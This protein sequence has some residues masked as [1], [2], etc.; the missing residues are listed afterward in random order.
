[1]RLTIAVHLSLPVLCSLGPTSGT[2]IIKAGDTVATEGDLPGP[3][4]A[5]ADNLPE[6]NETFTITLTEVDGAGAEIADETGV[7]DIID[8]TETRNPLS[9]PA[10]SLDRLRIR[11]GADK[12]I[13][14]SPDD[15]TGFLDAIAQG[16]S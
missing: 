14:V 4:Q 9:S 7:A 3:F 5:S 6:P 8:V 12:H 1:M 10:L 15:K 11:Y 16:G 13:M 2:A